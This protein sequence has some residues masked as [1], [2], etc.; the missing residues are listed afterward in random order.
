MPKSTILPRISYGLGFG[1][2]IGPTALPL[3][4]AIATPALVEKTAP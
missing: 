3:V 2:N 4:G 1:I